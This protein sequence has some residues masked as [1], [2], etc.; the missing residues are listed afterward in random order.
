MFVV[1]TIRLGQTRTKPTNVETRGHPIQENYIRS[2]M[3]ATALP[4]ISL[5]KFGWP[6]LL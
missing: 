4:I 1:Q 2:G 5:N 6:W 3:F